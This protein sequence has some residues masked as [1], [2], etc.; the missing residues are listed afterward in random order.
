M[1]MLGEEMRPALQKAEKLTVG[2][3]DAYT[4]SNTPWAFLPG[5]KNQSKS[6]N[7]TRQFV[8][9]VFSMTCSH[10]KIPFNTRVKMVPAK[11]LKFEKKA[12]LPT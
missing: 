8:Y 1:V 11:I 4:H 10:M 5:G 2:G 6:L 9:A 3:R 12:S 7:D